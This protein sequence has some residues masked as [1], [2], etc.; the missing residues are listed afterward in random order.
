MS[1]LGWW[2]ITGVIVVVMGLIAY[3]LCDVSSRC[4]R[5]EEENERDIYSHSNRKTPKS[6]VIDKGADEK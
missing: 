2:I 3:S 4:S 1:T 5:E 6:T